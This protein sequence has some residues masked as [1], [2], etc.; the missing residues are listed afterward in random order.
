MVMA[1]GSIVLMTW[2]K[3]DLHSDVWRSADYGVTWMQMN[4]S[5]GWS[6]RYGHSIVAMPDGSIVLLGGKE[7][8]RTCDDIWRFIPT[9]ASVQ[10]PSHRDSAQGTYTVALQSYNAY[11]YSGMKKTGYI[12]QEE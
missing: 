10:N 2:Y 12:A 3:G 8:N 4:K 6:S 9:S 11:G 7:Q 5:A 1:D